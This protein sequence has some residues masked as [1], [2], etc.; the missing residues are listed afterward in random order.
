MLL[1][2]AILTILFGGP[3]MFVYLMYRNAKLQE[4]ASCAH[5]C[6]QTMADFSALSRME[7]GK[8]DWLWHEVMDEHRA[9]LLR[10]GMDVVGAE[11]A[12]EYRDVLFHKGINSLGRHLSA[13]S[14]VV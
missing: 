11:K 10:F 2:I 3:I 8:P 12:N 13:D 14:R 9:F 5:Y 4:K 7:D 6:W 1:D